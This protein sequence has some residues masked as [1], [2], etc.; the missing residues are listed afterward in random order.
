MNANVG[1]YLDKRW[2]WN[3]FPAN[4]GYPELERAQMRYIGSGGSPKGDASSLTPGAF[5]CS[6]IYQEPGRKASVHHH[7]IEELF[8]VHAGELTMTWQFGDETVDFI[9]RAGDAVL[10]PPSRPHG[11]RN[12]GTSD[13]VLQ[14]MV[15][16]AGPML[17]TYTDHPADHP[18]SPFRPAPLERREAYLEETSRYVARAADTRPQNEAV[19]GGTFRAFPY[20]MD[21]KYGG[22]VRPTNFCFSVDTLTRGGRTPVYARSVEEAFMVLEGVLDLEL[23]DGSRTAMERLGP[24]DLA[25]V[26]AGVMRAVANSDAATVRFASVVG[27]PGA[28]P[29]GWRTALAAAR[30]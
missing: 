30:A 6:L 17:P 11:F 8:F 23:R 28:A 14:I 22:L 21:A 15:A 5:S 27:D 4:D 3:A 19:E 25:L 12:D 2:D 7:Q 26:P 18:T 1:R 24:R 9:L 20:V 29:L 16:T 10:N 13:C